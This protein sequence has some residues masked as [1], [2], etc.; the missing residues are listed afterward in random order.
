MAS[1]WEILHSSGGQTMFALLRGKGRGE[2][3]WLRRP[4]LPTMERRSQLRAVR[5]RKKKKPPF[6]EGNV[7]L[8]NAWGKAKRS[9]ANAGS[10]NA[11]AGSFQMGQDSGTQRCH[12]ICRLE[13]HGY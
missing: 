1:N 3:L 5:G 8:Q 6:T 2:T 7:A 11:M 12:E 9:K 4:P 13:R 10:P